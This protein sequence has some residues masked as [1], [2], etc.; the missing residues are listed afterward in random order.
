MSE[1]GVDTTLGPG[2][3]SL[4]YSFEVVSGVALSDTQ[5]DQITRIA[6]Y[7]KPGHTHLLQIVEP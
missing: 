3:Q 6:N 2:E 1:L 5:R 4:L 7:M